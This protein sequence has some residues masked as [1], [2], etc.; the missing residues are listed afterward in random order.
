MRVPAGKTIRGED[1]PAGKVAPV[2]TPVYSLLV[3]TA[4]GM[5]VAA[6]PVLL[7]AKLD[8]S[9]AMVV[10]KTVISSNMRF[11]FPVGLEGT[12][13]HYFVA[14]ERHL[15]RTNQN[16]VEIPD[17]ANIDGELYTINYSMG[18][19]AQHYSTAHARARA[20]MRI[21]A[22]YGTAINFPGTLVSMHGKRSKFS[23]PRGIGPNKA[24]MYFD[25]RMLAEV[26]EAEGVDLRVLYLR[27]PVKGILIANTV[28]RHFQK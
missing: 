8:P 18:H 15:F 3:A 24:L 20:D 16:L 19:S 28:H 21:L 22:Q 14:V 17:R 2:M 10:P 7:N 13:H 1:C 12:G 9:S 25:L 27:R 6:T 23:Y 5:C 26:A 11:V 4:M